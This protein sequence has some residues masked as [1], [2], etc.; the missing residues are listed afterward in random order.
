M[1]RDLGTEQAFYTQNLQ[2]E[3]LI[4]QP[5]PLKNINASHL[6]MESG[7]HGVLTHTQMYRTASRDENNLYLFHHWG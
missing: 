3:N 5:P 1:K 7:N 4:A 2:W 6:R